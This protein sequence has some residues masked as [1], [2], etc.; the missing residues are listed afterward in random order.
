LQIVLL[1]AVFCTVLLHGI[2][3]NEPG[4]WIT[5]GR[6]YTNQ[7]FV[8]FTAIDRSNVTRLTPAWI[9]QTGT[10]G[11]EQTQPLV[12]GGVMYVTMPANDV[13]AIDAA[14]GDEIWRYHHQMRSPMPFEQGNRGAAVAYGKAFERPTTPA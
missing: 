8:S 14:T 3:A 1:A 11:S 12:V 9:Y 7:R 5:F 13:A 10:L 6:D 2:A 4:D